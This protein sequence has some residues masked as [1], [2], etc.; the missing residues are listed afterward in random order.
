MT[1]VQQLRQ[2]AELFRRVSR[3]PIGGDPLVDR[4][5]LALADKLDHEADERLEY[6][7]RRS[8]GFTSDR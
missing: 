6:L 2:K 3:T 5:L 1:R 8:E 7:K 4:E